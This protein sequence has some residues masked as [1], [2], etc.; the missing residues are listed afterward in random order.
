ML[1]NLRTPQNN[2]AMLQPIAHQQQIKKKELQNLL[3]NHD[4]S[5]QSL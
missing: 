1:V 3:S 2:Q 4:Q 5:Y